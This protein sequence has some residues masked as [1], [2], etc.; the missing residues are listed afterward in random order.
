M[1][2]LMTKVVDKVVEERE[3]SARVNG[4]FN[5]PAAWAEY[6]LGVKL[7]SKQREIAESVVH[8]KNVA[9]KAGHG[10]GK[11]FLVAVLAC[12][13][14]DTR[15][16]DVRV[17][18]TAPSV[19]QIGAI[20][21]NEIRKMK[22]LIERRYKEG[23][24][25]H[26]LP[27]NINSDLKDNQWKGAD[28]QSI[29]FGKKPPENKEDDAFQGIHDG[30]V[31][32]IGDEACHDAQTD[33]LTARGWLNWSQVREDDLFLSWDAQKGV[34][35]YL[36]ATRLVKYAYKGAMHHYKSAEA[37]FMVTP[38]HTMLYETA[39][40]PGVIRRD[41][42]QDITL[43]N[44]FMFRN[45]QAWDGN[46]PEKF[47]IPAVWGT[48]KSY[49]KYEFDAEDWAAFLGWVGSEGS[50]PKE[51]Y[52]VRI[53]QNKEHFR[54]E[55]RELLTRMNLP[56]TEDSDHFRIHCGRLAKFLGRNG[57]T[58]LDKRV[59]EYVKGW[60]KRLIDV[61][62][63]AYTK[64]DG[65]QK[66]A[67][68]RVI[69]TSGVGMSNDL[70]E[71]AL[72]AGYGSTISTR[73]PA[74]GQPLADGRRITST[75]DGYVVSVTSGSRR[76]RVRK[77]HENI[78][79]Y[80]G[81]V[82]CATLPKNNTLFTRRNGKTLWSGNCGLS[83]EI[84]DALSN[85][86]SNEGSRRILIA[87]PTNPASYFA[88][89]FREDKGW[90][91]HTISV[92]DSP[93][94]TDEKHEMTAEALEKLSGPTYAEDKAKEYGIDSAR[95]KARVLGEFAFDMG[96]SLIT[97][98]DLAVGWDTVTVPSTDTRP[99]LGVDV[100]RMGEDKTVIYKNHDGHVRYYNSWG[101]QDS[102]Q[103]ANEIHKA[104][105][106]TGAAEVRIDASGMG[107]PICD[108]VVALSEG[109]YAVIQ[110]IGQASSPDRRK[111]HNARAHWYDEFRRRV[112]SGEFDFPN[113]DE[114]DT[115][116]DELM[117]IE[118]KFFPYGGLLIE[119]KD[120]MRKRGMKSPDHADALIYACADMSHLF[121]NPLANLVN[122]QQIVM[123]MGQFEENWANVLDW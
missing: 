63:D 42:M 34:T 8:N 2:F 96:N 15:Y 84:I 1:S 53:W 38:N 30:G 73:P 77:E 18:T 75:R 26:I 78:V 61:Y 71:L 69:Y 46:D 82:Y 103:T 90:T 11:S 87:N 92:F 45:I 76:I 110:M 122:G 55:I 91:L 86:T 21:W 22:A 59:P 54:D 112:R 67:D 93:N 97:E 119:S 94:F 33:V 6:M 39:I 35:E 52:D 32:A 95:Y 118:Y 12:W 48:R 7:W 24:V 19:Q 20:V 28:G 27:G 120:D 25:D 44:K 121:S 113:A 98:P 102:I 10:V 58:T 107:G 37:D 3:R 13:W 116:N 99:V 16:P 83:N 101:K 36:P 74:Q 72:K 65:Y 64:G 89:L 51:G 81:M 40:K 56:F 105:M 104:A 60:S 50:L 62:L 14:V 115:V 70:Q 68:R 88:S 108:Q 23:K 4:Y 41:E 123:D 43:S 9:V 47:V 66:T 109:A 17:A 106:E 5:D 100:A 29:A 117:S 79:D 49:D 57:R 80:D 31:L 111:W 85:I 114:D